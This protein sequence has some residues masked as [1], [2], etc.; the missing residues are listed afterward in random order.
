MINYKNRI[1]NDAFLSYYSNTFVCNTCLG[2]GTERS[3]Y[4]NIT[5]I[6]CDGTG[7][8]PIPLMEF[9]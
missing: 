8:T 5:C 3:M 4:G 1:Y 6:H 7:R 9:L 2:K